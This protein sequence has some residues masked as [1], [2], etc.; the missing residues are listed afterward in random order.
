MIRGTTP[1]H[2]FTLPFDT[3]KVKEIK[4]IYAQEEQIVLEKTIDDCTLEG[5]TAS[6]KLT[7]EDTLL[8]DCHKFVQIQ[9]RVLTKN[10]EA[11]ASEIENVKVGKC[12]DNEV[13][14]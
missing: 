6:V 3:D 12:L 10:D 5:N 7:Q 1:T 14:T 4:I 13:L 2:Y 8:F 9:V 11:M